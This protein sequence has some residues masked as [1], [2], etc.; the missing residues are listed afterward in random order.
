[1]PRI[2]AK[3]IGALYSTSSAPNLSDPMITQ[4]S[5]RNAAPAPKASPSRNVEA[6][7]R[8]LFEE[9]AVPEHIV[10]Q[11]LQNLTENLAV[12][13]KAIGTGFLRIALA[14]LA[15]LLLDVGLIEELGIGG[16]QI[17]RTGILLL[18]FPVAVAFLNYQ[19][20]SRIGFAQELRTV[21]ALLY[22]H[23]APAVYRH[24]LD[25]LTH[26]PSTRNVESYLSKLVRGSGRR[27]STISTWLVAL[28]MIL[29]PLLAVGYCLFRTFVAPD[30]PFAIWSVAALIAV[31]LLFHAM[32]THAFIPIE[33][34]DVSRNRRR[35]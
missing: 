16:A 19:M 2:E 18:L 26:Y 3:M 24:H 28:L 9:P 17:K 5:D 12:T 7:V 14:F 20:M 1:M 22:E 30:V 23:L 11:Y 4:N 34:Y 29:A 33:R 32:V 31:A 35:E 6:E 25:L 10:L 15:F 13:E 27:I 21:I 8:S